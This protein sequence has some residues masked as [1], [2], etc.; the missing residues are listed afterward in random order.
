MRKTKREKITGDKKVDEKTKRS[1]RGG[2]QIG[3]K[4]R[5]KNNSMC[6]KKKLFRV[7]EKVRKIPVKK[8]QTEFF[9]LARLFFSFFSME[10]DDFFFIF[11]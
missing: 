6:G 11:Y 7:K 10:S 5:K 2:E 1:G 9:L 4:K 3:Y 8:N